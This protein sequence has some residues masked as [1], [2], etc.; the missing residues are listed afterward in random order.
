LNTQ[1]TGE[2][3]NLQRL[4]EVGGFAITV[5]PPPPLTAAAGD[6]VEQ[7]AA[8]ANLF[9]AVLAAD[10][11]G[12]AVA[13]SSLALAVLFKRAGIEAIAQFSGRDRNRLAL[14]S[15][16][17]GLGALGIPNLLVDTRPV[18]RTSLAQHADARL[19]TDLDGPALLA[20][21][22][23]MRD[24]ASFIS[25]ASIK[26]PPALY[27]GALFS[28]DEQVQ[29]SAYVPFSQMSEASRESGVSGCI[30]ITALSSAQFVVTPPVHDAHHFAA[31]L[32]AFQI[33]HP[34]FLQT[35]P[36]IVSLPLTTDSPVESSA[37][38]NEA[39]ETGVQHVTSAI[40]VLK[41]LDGIRGF[42]IVLGKQADLALLEQ[43]VGKVRVK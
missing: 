30:S 10:A 12:S 5:Q 39:R 9:D 6:V 14:Q 16:I 41:G 38:P 32:V 8:Q 29:V 11:P 7:V 19:I 18:V 2:V 26:K 34:D 23:R 3:S 4:W 24:E 40:G 15:D 25:G 13:L 33:A 27:V 21:A 36:L 37:A 17:L 31:A 1:T 28:L 43:V 22:V 35:R 42:N 20:A